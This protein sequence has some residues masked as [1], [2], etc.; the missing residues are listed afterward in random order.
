MTFKSSPIIFHPGPIQFYMSKAPEGT[1]A[2][3]WD[4]SGQTWFK[5]YSEPAQV[6]GSQLSWASL[7]E[8]FLH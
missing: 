2:S 1:A 7:S 6:S 8:L 5:I 4:G 3:A